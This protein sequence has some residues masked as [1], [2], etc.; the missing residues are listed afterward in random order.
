MK[1]KKKSFYF[2]DYAEPEFLN[3]KKTNNIKI[4]LNRLTFLSFIFFSLVIIF[5]IKVIYLSL[6]S[7]K[8][9]FSN[10]SKKEFFK[11]RRDI[12][13]RNGSVIATNVILY[14]V[15]VRPKLLKEKEKKKSIDQVRCFIS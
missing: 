12:V 14:D 9:F 4:S 11:N 8:I 6:S 7:E 3:D 5:S 2:K 10:Y 13:D 15:G 1:K